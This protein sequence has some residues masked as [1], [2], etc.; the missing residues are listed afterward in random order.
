MQK[1]QCPDCDNSAI[2]S[3][4]GRTYQVSGMFDSSICLVLKGREDKVRDPLECPALEAAIEKMIEK[5][6]GGHD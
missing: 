1:V 5:W 4:L 6:P 3:Q 2:V